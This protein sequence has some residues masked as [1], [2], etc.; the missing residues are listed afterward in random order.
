MGRIRQTLL[1]AAIVLCGCQAEPIAP[2]K[3]SPQQ[4]IDEIKSKALASKGSGAPALWKFSDED[5]VIYIFGTIH[6]LPGQTN[7]RTDIFDTAFKQSDILVL[8]TDLTSE[9]A[10][11]TLDDYQW[12]FG[13][14]PVGETL[15]EHMDVGDAYRLKSSIKKLGH[16]PDSVQYLQPWLAALRVSQMRLEQSGFNAG[17][18]VDTVLELE[19][20]SSA[21]T[22]HYLESLAEQ[23]AIFRE[24][25]IQEQINSLMSLTRD[26]TDFGVEVQLISDEWL[27]G[28]VSGLGLLVANPE[29]ARSAGSYD[30][31]IRTRNQ[32]WAAQI[33]DLFAKQDS[34][35]MIAVGAAHLSGPDS[36]INM[37]GTKDRT[38]ERLQ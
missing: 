14:L 34:T 6:N 11:K 15:F 5:T 17:Q 7:W 27:D 37:V 29:L 18:G 25:D 1:G 8:E 31:L 23:M 36:L 32:K 2:T 33:E 22:L 26:Y 30:A 35:I 21:K 20:K 38:M 16:D 4:H 3:L 9:Q 24:A 10:R 12:D 19:A 28:D 13:R